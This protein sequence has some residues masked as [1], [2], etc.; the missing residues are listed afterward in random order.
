[1]VGP[2]IVQ[3]LARVLVMEMSKAKASDGLQGGLGV[4][5]VEA[6]PEGAVVGRNNEVPTVGMPEGTRA[7]KGV[8]QFDY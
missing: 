1:V 8:V 2:G 4:G 5:G 6:W 3:I 7:V